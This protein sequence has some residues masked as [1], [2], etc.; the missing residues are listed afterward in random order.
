[1]PRTP[2]P[3]ERIEPTRWEHYGL[4]RGVRSALYACPDRFSTPTNIEGLLA[5]DIFT[6]NAALAATIEDSM[7]KTLNDLRSVWDPSDQYE[8]Y[9]LEQTQSVAQVF[10][11][12]AVNTAL[13]WPVP[14][15]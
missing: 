9:A 8:T 5:T 3:P 7:V 1:M 6:L 2:E 11:Q 13:R 12:S 14:A 4:W 15:C 10:T